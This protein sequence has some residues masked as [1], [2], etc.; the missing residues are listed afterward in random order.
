[1][2]NFPMSLEALIE[3]AKAEK[4]GYSQYDAMF[5]EPMF[6]VRLPE[7]PWT[8]PGEGRATGAR[9]PREIVE[10]GVYLAWERH[11][12]EDECLIYAPKRSNY[13]GG[14]S[15]G[16]IALPWDSVQIIDS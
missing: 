7:A 1:M 8:C 12:D 4:A 9:I 6:R 5:E 3:E 16:F 14:G 11:L 10:R 2:T 15:G 13:L